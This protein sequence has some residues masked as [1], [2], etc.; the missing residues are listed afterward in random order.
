[1]ALQVKRMQLLLKMLGFHP[2]KLHSVVE[3]HNDN[4]ITTVEENM[5]TKIFKL[6]IFFYTEGAF[7]AA[8]RP[9]R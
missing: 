4:I 8:W 7:N 5:Q 6:Y 2:F 1:M 9:G 3:K